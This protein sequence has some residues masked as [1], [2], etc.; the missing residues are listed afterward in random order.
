LINVLNQTPTALDQM[1]RPTTTGKMWKIP[2]SATLNICKF[3]N[4]QR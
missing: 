4:V 2:K 1:T 3:L